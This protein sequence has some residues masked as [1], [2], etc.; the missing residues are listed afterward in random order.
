[1]MG[2]Q[3]EGM[4]VC[5]HAGQIQHRFRQALTAPILAPILG[6]RLMPPVLIAVGVAQVGLLAAGQHG[7]QCPIKAALGIP[8][9]GCGLSTATLL[10]LRG[11]WRE[12]LA[13]HA[14]APV[15]LIGLVLIAVVSL[16]PGRWRS[17]AISAVA[18][19]ERRTGL[20]A[21]VLLALLGYWGIRLLSMT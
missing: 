4:C 14:F 19:V 17:Q 11:R 18:A 3:G 6:D 9:P 8:C 2:V 16:L 5:W 13:M 10:L 21:I 1:M 15:F 7:W 12:S 20:V